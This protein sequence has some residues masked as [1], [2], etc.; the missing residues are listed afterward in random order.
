MDYCYLAMKDVLW[1]GLLVLHVP[2]QSYSIRLM[3]GILVVVIGS[4][5]QLWILRQTQ[6]HIRDT[7]LHVCHISCQGCCCG[8]TNLWG[9]VKTSDHSVFSPALISKLSV[10]DQLCSCL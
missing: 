4:H 2:D 1:C 6:Q 5:Q 9:T 10:Q 3:G 7:R 8:L